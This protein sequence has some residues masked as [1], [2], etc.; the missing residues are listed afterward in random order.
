LHGG[1]FSR[2]ARRDDEGRE[3]EGK[4]SDERSHPALRD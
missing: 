3:Y 1:V 2:D 4:H